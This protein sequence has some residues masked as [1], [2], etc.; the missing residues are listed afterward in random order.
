[1]Y[2]KSLS[3]PHL[4]WMTLFVVAP[5]LIIFIYA[6]TVSG[7]G[8]AV[9]FTLDN[10]VKFFDKM[11][12]EI[13]FN[14]IWVSFLSVLVCFFLGY[15]AALILANKDRRRIMSGKKPTGLLMLFV[16][17]MWMNVMLKLYSWLAILNPG[18]LLTSL[19]NALGLPSIDIMHTYTAIVLGTVYDYIPFMVLPIYSVLIKIDTSVIE[20]AQDLGAN[21]AKVFLKVILPLSLPGIVSGFT[22][23]FLP[24]LTSFYIVDFFGGGQFMLIGNVIEMNFKNELGRNFGSSISI[25]LMMFAFL[26]M[27]LMKLF[28]RSNRQMSKF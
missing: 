26:S 8:G 5:M 9:T 10:F 14:S 2:K 25:I 6:F 24:A 4:V 15:P 7:D 18:G 16:M 12:I 20:A 27:Y 22:M 21:P 1:M 13:F 17:P 3:Y 28:N 11:Y 23:V 19:T